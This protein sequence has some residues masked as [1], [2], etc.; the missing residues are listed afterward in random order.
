MYKESESIV[1]EI[2]LAIREKQNGEDSVEVASALN[3]LVDT[4][5]SMGQLRE[6]RFAASC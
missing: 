3:I 6:S 5:E 2:L 4:Y 1:K